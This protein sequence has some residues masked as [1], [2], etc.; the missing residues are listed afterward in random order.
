MFYEARTKEPTQACTCECHGRP[1][2]GY[3]GLLQSCALK[4][5]NSIVWLESFIAHGCFF[6]CHNWGYT[7]LSENGYLGK[8]LLLYGCIL[9]SFWHCY[10]VSVNAMSKRWTWKGENSFQIEKFCLLITLYLMFP[11]FHQDIP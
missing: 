11:H 8:L 6:A 3:H 5:S 2:G 10:P 1:L 9:C 4:G 7:P